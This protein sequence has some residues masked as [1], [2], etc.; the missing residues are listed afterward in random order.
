MLKKILFIV[1]LSILNL[2]ADFK[3]KS[4][5]ELKNE[6]FVKQSYEESCG[7]ASM[8]NL[9]NFFSFEQMSEKDILEFFNQKTDSLSFLE[10]KQ[11]AIK[12][13]YE[14][15]GY[16]L[17]REDFEKL[18]V[19]VIVKIEKDPRFPHF[20]VIIPYNGDFIK[21][22]D[23]N[24]GSYISSKSEFYSIWDKDKQGGYALIILPQNF[25]N[26]SNKKLYF[27]ND[28]LLDKNR[29]NF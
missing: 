8:A 22:L 10:L 25:E 21:I 13:G 17:S 1:L 19:P 18:E 2:W 6:N 14:S 16:Q 12:I 7:A 24:F 11:V 26:Y 4:I 29:K 9:I 5:N 15:E 27:F 3:V 20:V 28:N 23:P